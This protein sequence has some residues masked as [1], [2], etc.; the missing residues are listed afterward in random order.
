MGLNSFKKKKKISL[1]TQQ[2]LFHERISPHI[3]LWPSE[4]KYTRNSHKCLVHRVVSK[5]DWIVALGQVTS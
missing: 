4:R 5:T 1:H 3:Q 2:L